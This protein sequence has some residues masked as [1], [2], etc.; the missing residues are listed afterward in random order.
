VLKA[1][2]RGMQHGAG[3]GPVYH[4]LLKRGR[5]V[6]DVIIAES[7]LDANLAALSISV[8]PSPGYGEDTH[9]FQIDENELRDEIDNEI[10]F[11]SEGAV[12]HDIRV[13]RHIFALRQGKRVSTIE[14]ARYVFLTTNSA[15]SRAAFSYERKNSH[16]WIFSAVV[17]DFH[18]SHLAWLKS[19]MA[20][21]DLP[22]ADI[23]ANCYAAMRPDAS[24]WNRYIA[25]LERLRAENKVSERDHE[26][27]R[28]SLHSPDELMDVTSGD[29]EGI[30]PANIHRILDRL[31]KTYAAEKERKL[32]HAWQQQFP[33]AHIPRS[34]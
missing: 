2:I 15:L 16:G 33:V 28:Y 8:F 17:T 12:E 3:R 9:Q 32:E 11:I 34:L 20:A 27:L 4:E 31:E 13:V 22:R 21:S 10:E 1:I 23:L 25:E 19:P 26:V 29:V 5:G 6:A 18:L 7:N 30:N 14:D 24:M